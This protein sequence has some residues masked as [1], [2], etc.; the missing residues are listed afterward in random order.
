MCF[1]ETYRTAW[2]RR[3][4]GVKSREGIKVVGKLILIAGNKSFLSGRVML[5]RSLRYYLV[6]PPA[7]K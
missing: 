1:F 3:E 5:F 6:S 4:R 7:K 2:E